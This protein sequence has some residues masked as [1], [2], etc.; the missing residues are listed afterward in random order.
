M[1]DA[2]LEDVEFQDVFLA[3]LPGR[4]PIK[5]LDV[6]VRLYRALSDPSRKLKLFLALEGE[7]IPSTETAFLDEVWRVW[8]MPPRM[9]EGSSDPETLMRLKATAG[10]LIDHGN[11]LNDDV[12]QSFTE[13]NQDLTSPV[14][15]AH[16]VLA[17]LVGSKPSAEK[18]F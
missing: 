13:L 18:Y 7:T 11:L 2:N 12:T 1:M 5:R 9:V 17:S 6:C 15:I 14:A 16:S 4:K 10:R 8:Q 3:A